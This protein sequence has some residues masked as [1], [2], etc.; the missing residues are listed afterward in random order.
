M[1][2]KWSWAHICPAVG[3]EAKNPRWASLACRML[4][5]TVKCGNVPNVMIGRLLILPCLGIK[6]VT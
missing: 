6:V 1:E 5:P 2:L 3:K 4:I